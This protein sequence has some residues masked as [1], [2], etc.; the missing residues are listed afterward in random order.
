MKKF[1]G[2]TAALMVC[3]FAACSRD[4]SSEKSGA[5]ISGSPAR[6]CVLELQSA[7]ADDETAEGFLEGLAASG[8]AEGRDYRASVSNAQGDMATLSSMVD[9]ALIGGADMLIAITTPCLQVA[10][11]R[12]KGRPVIFAGVA[13]PVIAGAGT[14]DI[15]HAA[16]VTGVYTMSDFAGMAR[17]L[18]GFFPEVKKIGTLFCTSEINSMYY[19]DALAREAAKV[20]I[21]IEAI[22]VATSAEVPDAAAALCRKGIHAVCQISDN[23]S[24]S[25]FAAILKAADRARIPVFAFQTSQA[26]AGA[27]AAIARDFRDAGRDAGG[28]AARVARGESPAAIPFQPC[29]KTRLT[30]NLR[31]ARACGVTING[32][33]LK[34]AHS[35]IE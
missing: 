7:P 15:H 10:L 2:I 17:L 8:L 6:I 33:L 16:N 35:V 19:K 31:A 22:A 18:S 11:Q 27:V 30:V 1:F 34:E 13:N 20:G 4:G 32:Q 5:A 24:A 25:S 12:G 29:K 23:I 26:R 9:A 28:L 3:F 21:S 14:D